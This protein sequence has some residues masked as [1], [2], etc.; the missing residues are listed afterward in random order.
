MPDD[1]RLLHSILSNAQHQTTSNA[2]DRKLQTTSNSDINVAN[3]GTAMRLLTAYFAQ[4]EG[5][6]VRLRGVER[7]HH[8]PIG[9]LV[10][11]LR[12]LGAD[13]RYLG[14][15]GFPPLE[16]RGRRLRLEQPVR[17]D[18]PA[19]TQFISAL[20]LIGARVETNCQSPYIDMT[21]SV[22]ARYPDVPLERDW[23]AA[24]FW[25]ER[26]LL[27]G[28][29]YTFPGL[30]EDSLQGDSAARTIFAEIE[31]RARTHAPLTLDFARTPDLY[32]AVAVTCHELGV[33]LTATGTESLRLKESD[34][35]AAIAE[36]L[37]TTSNNF[38]QLQTTSNSAAPLRAHADHR[39]AMA[40]LAAGY[41]VDDEACVS[42]SY[43][44]FCLQLRGVSRIIP[45]RGINDEGKGKKWALHRLVPEAETEWVWLADDDVT[46]PSCCPPAEVL[47]EAD[48]IIL[49][50]RMQA[51]AE[52]TS[53]LVRLQQLEYDAIQ[54]LTCLTAKHGHAVMCSGANLL[55]R[56]EVWL[57]L[58]SELHPEVPSGDDMFLL[59]AMKRHGQRII[60]LEDD[61][62]TAICTAE[63]TLRG[64]LRQRMRWAG[65]AAHYTDR[66]ILL[67]GAA[68]VLSN[69]LAAV[70]PIWL[71]GKW[72]VDT[73]LIRTRHSQGVAQSET[74]KK[75]KAI[76]LYCLTLVLTILY[77]WYLLLCLLGGLI[78]SRHSSPRW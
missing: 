35:L 4:L 42:K 21:R 49:P 71:I 73:R 74:K 7:M 62:Y 3:C 26:S 2:T 54:A 68:T 23:S 75:R 64:L 63:P 51:P 50:L 44:D 24:A 6:H 78:R 57:R 48:M 58:E 16:I 39:I 41:A 67:A 76:Q 43:P 59:E 61:R 27:T 56:R 18:N 47:S 30:E 37:Q 22:M 60:C 11:A 17:L 10:E 25:L 31:Q 32:P 55:V 36:A 40:L 53:L 9:Q 5:C 46:L 15:E 29:E 12:S 34:R 38:K 77:P 14:E 52:G 28:E 70:C 20:L 33:P 45:R 66:D 69:L 19:S 8:R 65:K 13:I 72:L 1:V